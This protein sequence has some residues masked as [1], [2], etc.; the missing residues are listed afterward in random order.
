[1]F[2]AFLVPVGQF[3][4]AGALLIRPLCLELPVFP[5]SL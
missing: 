1:M 3:D 2:V 4:F 5:K